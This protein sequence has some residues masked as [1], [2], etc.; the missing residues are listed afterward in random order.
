VD[1]N[2]IAFV[3]VVAA[4]DDNNAHSNLGNAADT[5]AAYVDTDGADSLR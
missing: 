5:E 4:A 2:D 3:V 1:E